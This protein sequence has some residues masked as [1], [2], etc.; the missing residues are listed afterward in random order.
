L[1]VKEI[2]KG[3]GYVK[4][5]TRPRR[6][7]K[8]TN[9]SMMRE[10]FEIG[11]DGEPDPMLFKGLAIEGEKRIFEEW[12]RKHPVI[13]IN[14]F[15]MSASD[16]FESSINFLRAIISEE[17]RRHHYLQ[18]SSHV[19]DSLKETLLKLEKNDADVGIVPLE[20][21]LTSLRLISEALKSHYREPC[22]V[23]IDEY[24]SPFNH[25]SQDSFRDKLLSN[26][27]VFFSYA[28]KGNRNVLL[29]V[30]T[31]CLRIANESIFTG[32]NNLA[33]FDLD[34]KRFSKF[35][36][37]T[38]EELAAVLQDKGLLDHFDE[39][40]TWYNGYNFGG[41]LVYNT[42][43]VLS[44]VSALLQDEAAMPKNHWIN[45]SRND[46]L[47]SALE[48]GYN[49]HVVTRLVAGEAVAL[50]Q[51]SDTITYRGLMREDSIWS[52]LYS[53]G[54]LTKVMGS[55]GEYRIPNAEVKTV[56]VE[57]YKGYVKGK[58]GLEK[59]K[60]LHEAIY[61]L[62]AGSIEGL[63]K[64]L[65]LSMSYHDTA[66]SH[67]D[68]YHDVFF[69]AL[70]GLNCLSNREAGHGRSDIEVEFSESLLVAVFEFKRFEGKDKSLSDTAQRAYNQIFGLG[71]IELHKARG[72]KI[73]AF[74]VGCSGK[75]CKVA[76]GLVS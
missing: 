42:S 15:A 5:I 32:A 22:I 62:D 55:N 64:E 59:L 30:V 67:E 57:F 4:L 61:T 1:L 69:G 43:S 72:F 28:F 39:F 37:M 60:N 49:Y 16:T 71:Y 6:F 63:L 46:I 50:P 38:H 58:L 76:G 73:A 74:G 26:L 25:K 24:D 19:L 68:V 29:N 20:K 53:S 51:I 14:L 75:D 33:V 8:S 54:Y 36:G 41:T 12:Y 65:L 40:K 11:R 44:H 52:I 66:V 21:L 23:L 18:D 45:T 35:Y 31:G 17:C 48:G 3:T 34:S 10:F 56:F 7:G 27:S 13:H 70:F 9:M 47:E 2:V